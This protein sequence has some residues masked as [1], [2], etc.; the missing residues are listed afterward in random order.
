MK[1]YKIKTF[2]AGYLCQKPLN[3]LFEVIFITA[4]EI[5]FLF[6]TVLGG[7]SLFIFGMNVMTEGL[8]YAVGAKL[9]RL[10]SKATK[11]RFN[12]L[13]LGTS[14][15]TTIHSSATIVML[16]GFVNAG[17]L[18]LG[19]SIAPIMGANIGTTLSM[20]AISFKISDYAFVAVALGLIVSMLSPNTKSKYL[21]RSILGFGLLFLGMDTMSDAI[22]PHRELLA[23]FLEGVDGSSLRGILTGVLISMILTAIWQS[24]GA[25]IAIIFA[26]ISASVFT[27]FDQV[28]PIV[29]GAHLG[30]C[31]TGIL[32]SMGTHIE[33]KRTA[34]THL[35]FNVWNVFLAI[36]L[37]PLFSWFIPITSNDLIRQTANYHTF[38]MIFATILVLP[39]SRKVSTFIRWILR[40]KKP[41]PE[42]SYLD[43]SLLE[44]PE[45]SIV[46][47]IQELQ[48]VTK[49]AEKSLRLIPSVII[50]KNQSENVS[51]IKTNEKV[52]NDIKVAMGEF[53]RTMTQKY[54]SRRQIIMAQHINRCMADIERVG[55]HIDLICDLSLKTP[56]NSLD[57]ASLDALFNLHQKARHILSQVINSLDPDQT[58]FQKSA[59]AI[60]LARDDYRKASMQ[61]NEVFMRK[62]EKHELSSSAAIYLKE[63]ISVM[64]RMIRHI[65]S[66]AL[67]QKHEDFWI[68]RSK[69]NKKTR[70]ENHFE[71]QR[72]NPD[73]YLDKLQ[74]ENYS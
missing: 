13:L 2:S 66:I 49:V 33:A 36:L 73:D 47:L 7:L 63:Y 27:R 18:T 62:V 22:K 9:Q 34:V 10:L 60:L 21:G 58:D 53:V 39:F 59:E 67:A 14:L 38:V 57:K 45:R 72:F 64:D 1:K 32:G 68:K 71:T 26:M 31:I 24:S 40:S 48:R 42:S 11:N 69:L 3:C 70:Q 56:S 50:Q 6:M 61:A 30:T 44:Y 65:K 52:I 43:Y 35:L 74:D 37:A 25:T 55:D 46:A 8:R 16:I 20:Q 17:L 19:Q 41:L 29:L 15:G 12:G 28:F 54:L 23:L 51:R 4:S 5:F